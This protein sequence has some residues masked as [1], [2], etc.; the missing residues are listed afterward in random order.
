MLH[1][2]CWR[3]RHLA[4][5]SSISTNGDSVQDATSVDDDLR[6]CPI[7]ATIHPP[8]DGSCGTIWANR[9][10]GEWESGDIRARSE[11]AVSSV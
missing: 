6:E 11:R 1:I 10:Q 4:E 7:G 9:R 3:S 5:S 8:L 2:T